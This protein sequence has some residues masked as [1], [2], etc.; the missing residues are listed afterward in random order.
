MVLQK[1]AFFRIKSVDIG[2]VFSVSNGK[3]F[4]SFPVSELM[5]GFRFGQFVLTKKLGSAIHV[6][7]TRKAQ[8]KKS[9]K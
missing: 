2:K 1:K 6:K 5:V 9:T 7:K 8:Q 4:I 3:T